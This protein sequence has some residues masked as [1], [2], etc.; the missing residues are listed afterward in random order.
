MTSDY[1][2]SCTD[3]GKAKS[4]HGKQTEEPPC[5]HC[6]HT[7][8][9]RRRFDATSPLPTGNGRVDPLATARSYKMPFGKYY[10]RPLG[11]IERADLRYLDWLNGRE[12]TNP[13]LMQHIAAICAA[14]ADDLDRM[15][16][17]DE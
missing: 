10:N 3:C 12:I 2:T 5:R 9:K 15:I 7:P 16:G 6:G 14:R 1:Q 8:E 17:A 13:R 4:W 11:E